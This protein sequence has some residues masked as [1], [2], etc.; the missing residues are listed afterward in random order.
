MRSVGGA[1]HARGMGVQDHLSWPYEQRPDFLRTVREFLAEGLALGL[2][3]VYLADSPREQLEADMVGIPDL[4]AALEGGAL[5]LTDLSELYPEG[6]LVDPTETLATYRA[7]VEDALA[8]GYAGLRVAAD[9]TPLVRTPE[10]LDAFAAWEHV[11]DRYMTRHPL[12]ALCGFDREQLPASATVALACLHPA[13]RAGMTPFYVYSP[14]NGADLA[15]AGEID[16]V[17]TDDFRTCLDRTGLE[18]TRELVVDGSWLDFIDHR[19][20]AGLAD[21]ARRF[22]V[23]A[24]LRTCSTMPGRLIELLGLEDIR[25]EFP[26]IEGV[27][28]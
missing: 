24:V 7:A 4:D 19:A 1:Q 15:L 10:Q 23:T 16:I 17:G 25:T 26:S 14:E 13:A 2:R 28:S 8:Q 21:Y 11:A 27:L 6:G 3:C 22:Q 18:L 12:S 5:S 9:S 20:L